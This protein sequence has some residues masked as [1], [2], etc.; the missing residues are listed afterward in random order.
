VVTFLIALLIWPIC[1]YVVLTST[2]MSAVVIGSWLY[3][4]PGGSAPR[5]TRIVVVIPAHNEGAGIVQ[6]LRDVQACDY[7][8]GQLKALV[9]ADNCEDDTA[10]IAASH[11]AEVFVRHDESARGK[12]PALNWLLMSERSYLSGFDVIAF[13]DADMNVDTHFASALDS[14]FA[15]PEV[16]VVQARNT[17][18]NPTGSWLAAIGFM[19]FA[20]VNHVRPAGRC[21]LGGTSG[22]K[23]SGM[24]FRSS[25]ILE[26]GWPTGSLAEDLDFGKDLSLGGRRIHYQPRAI[27]TSDIA[28]RIRQVT[29]QQARW[30]GGR[31]QGFRQSLPRFL[32]AFFRSPSRLLLDELLDM[33]VPPLSMVAL[34]TALG[35]TASLLG[36]PLPLWPFVLALSVFAAAVITGLAQLKPPPRTYAYLAMAPAFVVLKLLLILKL[37]LSPAQKDWKRT[38]RDGEQS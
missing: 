35:I 9:I 15:D 20:Y 21:Y 24:A 1:A 8:P 10:Q 27:V 25:L 17:V 6:T 2:Y 4:P 26:T 23:G 30:E 14:T 29:V 28:S 19:S 12:G 32:S 33:L 22:L 36:A 34:A 38:P 11:G 18:A 16:Q 31:S 3:R 37:A 13:V 5:S 7:P